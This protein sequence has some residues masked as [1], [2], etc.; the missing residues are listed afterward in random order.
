[1]H[2]LIADPAI[3]PT[4]EQQAID[5]GRLHHA[6][7]LRIVVSV[8]GEEPG[9][10]LDPA[11]AAVAVAVPLSRVRVTSIDPAAGSGTE[12]TIAHGEVTA[13]GRGAGGTPSGA[14][15]AT[16]AALRQL[17][18]SIPFDVESAV[19]LAMGTAGAVLVH[20]VGKEGERLGVSP[21]A[22]AEDAAVRATLQALN[23]WL[24]DPGRRPMSL[25]PASDRS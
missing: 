18:W 13:T 14:A 21:G 20:L 19:R 1:M 6:R 7:P 5:L 8:E 10:G 16:I 2:V 17:G 3:R 15:S 4:V 9:T 11:A 24:D 12:V 22:T 23:R 25:R